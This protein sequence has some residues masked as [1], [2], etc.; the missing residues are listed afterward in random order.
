MKII[1]S[2]NLWYL[3]KLIMWVYN[4]SKKEFRN[5]FL[6]ETKYFKIVLT[7]KSVTA[8]NYLS[9]D[10]LKSIYRYL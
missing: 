7:G 2:Q 10:V 8:D 6:L 9:M 3:I 4:Y 5:T 1:F